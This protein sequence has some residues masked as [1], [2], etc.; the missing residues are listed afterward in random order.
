MDNAKHKN[1]MYRILTDIFKDSELKHI[2]AFKGGTAL[3]FFHNLP[4]FSVDLDF[5]ILDVT[6]TKMV[7]DR[8][9]EIAL[10]YGRIRD[11]Q[12]KHFGP[13][14]V[15]DYE[16]GER[17]LKIELSTRHFDNHY[18][19]MT[20]A[21][22]HIPTMVKADMFAHKLCALL[23]R[24][25]H[26]TGRDIFD[27][28]FF[29]EHSQSVHQGIVEQRMKKPLQDYIDDCI[30]V[31]KTMSNKELMSNVGD[32]LEGK[33]KEKMRSGKLLSETIEL[34]EVF[35]AFP[36]IEEYPEG[37][38]PLKHVE[39]VTNPKGEKFLAASVGEQHF[40]SKILT[41][42]EKAQYA[43]FPTTEDQGNFL[44]SL[45]KKAYYPDWIKH[46]EQQSK[47]LKR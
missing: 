44:Q 7:Y 40:T 21:G 23:T 12:M 6:Q 38:M 31:L 19:V 14:I 30:S 25:G 11:E 3:M 2:L 1:K 34:L 17:N 39:L 15:V 24:N 9:R 42:H 43:A 8:V 33:Q 22:M 36:I 37:K 41:P 20:F 13:I 28:H 4:R 5:N 35:K 45:A 10:K 46:G 18:E 32:L 27:I 16:A 29:L 47:S 26:I